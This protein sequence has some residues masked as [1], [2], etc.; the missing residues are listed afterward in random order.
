[1]SRTVSNEF[2]FESLEVELFTLKSSQ[3]HQES[4]GRPFDRK[5]SWCEGIR[6][7]QSS[8]R[9][10]RLPYFPGKR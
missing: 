1:M 8:E 2:A 5:A 7:P 3:F 4:V 10:L 9:S 6:E